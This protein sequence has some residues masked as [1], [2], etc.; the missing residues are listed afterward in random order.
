MIIGFVES[1][2]ENF[3][4]AAAN[5]FY[6]FFFEGFAV[7]SWLVDVDEPLER[8]ERLDDRAASVAVADAVCMVFYFD[9]CVLV[10]EVGDDFFAGFEAI[11]A[12]VWLACLIVE[13]AV[14]V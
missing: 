1:V 9:E 10:L 13:G 4:I 14:F 3:D 12:C 2:G 5:S 11:E 8:Y 7:W 6:G